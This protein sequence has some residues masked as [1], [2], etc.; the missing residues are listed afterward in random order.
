MK[1]SIVL[2]LCF[3]CLTVFTASRAAD[4][5]Q[6]KITQVV[7]DVEIISAADQKKVNAA[8]ND[9]F[10]IPDILR[11]GPASRAELVALDNTVTRVGANTIFSFDP[12]SRTVDLKQGSLLF[13]SPHGKG[14]G[15]IHTGSA[16]ASVLGSTLIVSATPNGGFK[17]IALEDQVEIKLPSGLHQ[18]LNPGQMTYILPGGTHLAPIV[19]F[20]LDDLVM[21]SLLVKGFNHPLPSIPLILLEIDKQTK[22]IKSGKV[23]DTGL[24]AGDNA[25]P[26]QVEVLDANTVQVAVNPQDVQTALAADA[27]INNSSLTDSK[28]P[29][30][31]NRIFLDPAFSLSGNSFFA[32]QSFQGFAA[33]NLAINT[34][35]SNPNGLTV[36]LSPYVSNPEFDFVAAKTLSI[37]GPVNFNGLSANN[38]LSLIGGEQM[39]FSPNVNVQ[40]NVG[41]FEL[42][43]A[44]T[45]TLNGVGL[46]NKVGDIGLT[47]G[48]VINLNNNTTIDNA[49][50]I[51]LTAA[52][53][54]NITS[55]GNV[56]VGVSNPTGANVGLSSD[57][58]IS[59]DAGAGQVTFSSRLG[60]VT[61]LN[62][63]IT[64]HFLT[65]NSGDSILLDA[66]GKTLAATGAGA[67]A[68]FTAP[69]VVSVNNANLTA[70]SVVNL[71]AN[72]IYLYNVA[73]G[74]PVN[75][76]SLNGEWNNGSVVY[77]DVNNLG[78]NTYQG[79]PIIAPDGFTGTIPGTSIT[80]GKLN[81][82]TGN[83]TVSPRNLKDA[84]NYGSVGSVS[85]PGGNIYQ[86]NPIIAATRLH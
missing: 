6:S 24:L 28:I 19:L 26:N 80:V 66:S 14:G 22:L 54:V 7:N 74:G 78:G 65:L 35:G 47:S 25:S 82:A 17:V 1:R 45:L 62:T 52:N 42:S 8:I 34:P 20:R 79:N 64:T 32:G 12:A 27:T 37:Q 72:T 63:S 58:T 73:F 15:S 67:T 50:K 11:T 39:T 57:T 59:T 30:P 10:M 4:F 40:A 31:P 46:V 49:G 21:N 36:D 43:T 3:T 68:S 76:K 69:N 70:F 16:T 44:A 75:L 83:A 13:H 71:A 81:G 33:H 51:T 56:N 86:V 53:A 38:K 2:S 5:K 48:S 85:K 29:V 18:S 60:S 41:D 55:D 23:T 9:I 61:V 77:G 84:W